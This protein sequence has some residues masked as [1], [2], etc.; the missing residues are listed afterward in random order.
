VKIGLE[1]SAV[2]ET[3][4]RQDFLADAKND[5]VAAAPLHRAMVHCYARA[6][7]RMALAQLS[8]SAQLRGF[9]AKAQVAIPAL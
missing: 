9:R 6:T 1:L 3:F 8:P 4:M 7:S 2:N 5:S